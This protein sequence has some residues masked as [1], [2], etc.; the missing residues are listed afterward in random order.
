MPLRLCCAPFVWENVT[1]RDRYVRDHA[2]ATRASETSS[3]PG[4]SS[5]P[6]CSRFQNATVLPR[7]VNANGRVNRNAS[8]PCR[9]SQ[10]GRLISRPMAC[11]MSWPAIAS[12]K[13]SATGMD[14]VTPVVVATRS[15]TTSR[16]SAT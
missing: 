3:T 15:S 12:T 4:V 9:A 5:M 13:V 1:A 16:L 7:A 6:S 14:A 8:L 2:S 10:C 11:A